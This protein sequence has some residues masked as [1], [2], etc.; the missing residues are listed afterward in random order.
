MENSS[1]ENV[2]IC[3]KLDPAVSNITEMA[4]GGS[5]PSTPV[6]PQQ[7]IGHIKTLVTPRCVSWVSGGKQL[8]GWDNALEGY[9]GPI[10]EL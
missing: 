8:Y 10:V 2:R 3:I 1:G 5:E 4:G 6:R 9:L 7:S